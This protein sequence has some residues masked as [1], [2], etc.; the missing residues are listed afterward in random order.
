[1]D[2]CRAIGAMMSVE[3]VRGLLSWPTFSLSSFSIVTRLRQMGIRPATIIDIGA[4]IGQFS[5]AAAKVFP[6][7]QIWAFE[8][9]PESFALLHKNLRAVPG[10]HLTQCAL[11]AASEKMAMNVNSHRHSSSLLA[12]GEVHS[13]AFPFAR[14][15][16]KVQV[17]VK[18]LDSLVGQMNLEPITLLKVDVQGFEAQVIRGATQSLKAIDF[19]IIEASFQPM[20]IGEMTF[21]DLANLM[22]A[23][24]FEFVGPLDWLS[25]P[26]SG[27]VLQID[28]L[29]RR[30]TVSVLHR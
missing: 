15:E 8:P 26:E 25:H 12:L 27:D 13:A 11:G 17:E 29:F 5:V 7:S 14:E 22:V 30:R 6:G 16:D 23:Q 2:K 9:I 1:M 10:A 19:V 3:A 24:G 21:V 28:A 4:N 20:Y 18:T